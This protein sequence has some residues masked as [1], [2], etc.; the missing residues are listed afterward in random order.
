MSTADLKEFCLI[1]YI[2]Q[3]MTF[4]QDK[5]IKFLNESWH[6]HAYK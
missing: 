6:R 4:I 2:A 5:I 3:A 1:L